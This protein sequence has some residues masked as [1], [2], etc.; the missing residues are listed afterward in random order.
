MKM[1]QRFHS[2]KNGTAWKPE[3]TRDSI[4]TF[5]EWWNANG[6]RVYSCSSTSKTMCR[7]AWDAAKEWK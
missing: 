6:A 2:H 4:V 7:Q 5:Q 3:V 1:R